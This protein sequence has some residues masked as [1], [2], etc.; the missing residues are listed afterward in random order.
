MKISQFFA[1]ID[2]LGSMDF[3]LW[4]ALLCTI[5]SL[6]TVLASTH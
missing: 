5:G 6:V 4:K 3:L 1:I 2:I